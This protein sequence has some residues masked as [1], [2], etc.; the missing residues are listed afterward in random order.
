M[1]LSF[2][3]IPA[4]KFTAKPSFQG[5]ID[6]MQVC[7]KTTVLVLS[8]MDGTWLCKDQKARE[9]LDKGIQVNIYDTKGLN[10]LFGYVTARPPVRLM[11]E[12][13]PVP[14]FSLTYNGGYI[15]EGFPTEG[16]EPLSEWTALNE[17]CNFDS[18]EVIDLTKEI[19]KE[20]EFSNFKIKTVG[21]VVKNLAADDCKYIASICIHK[22]SIVLDKDESSIILEDKT[23]KVPKQVNNYINRIKE[24]L[25]QKNVNFEVNKPYLFKGE[26]Y[27]MFDI[28]TPYANKGKA[29]DFLVKDLKLNSENLIIAGDGGNDDV[30]MTSTDAPEGDGRKLIV[31][32]P[33]SSLRTSAA[34]K[35]GNLVTI[36]PNDEHSSTGVLKGIKSHLQEIYERLE[37]ETKQAL[38]DERQIKSSISHAEHE[39]T[40]RVQYKDFVS[41]D[42]GDGVWKTKRI[43]K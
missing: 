6:R 14:N 17:T 27:V 37:P 38:D 12:N 39:G 35:S 10:V 1:N 8:D 41:T 36:R 9:D 3:S 23:F 15:H 26:P 5:S 29:V 40:N 2:K 30:M 22:D 33:N 25:E 16:K 32:G 4:N 21:E 28:A 7:P 11:K 24:E 20:K 43:E 31:V 42:N 18:K 34:L 13:P 19:G